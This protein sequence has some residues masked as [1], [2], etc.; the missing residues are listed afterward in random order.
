MCIIYSSHHSD[1]PSSESKSS[2]ESNRS[3]R[4]S[5]ERRIPTIK[6]A[7]WSKTPQVS[8]FQVT[9]V[10]FLDYWYTVPLRNATARHVVRVKTNLYSA[11]ILPTRLS[12]DIGHTGVVIIHNRTGHE[13]HTDTNW[14][15]NKSAASTGTIACGHLPW[16]PDTETVNTPSH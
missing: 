14:S 16:S 9:L 13:W 10:V 3:C 6:L 7:S 4:R 11:L 2:N 8:R 5:P 12:V 1:Q 15:R